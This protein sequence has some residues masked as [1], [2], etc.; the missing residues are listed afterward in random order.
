M[1]PKLLVEGNACGFHERASCSPDPSSPAWKRASIPYDSSLLRQQFMADVDSNNRRSSHD[2]YSPTGTS[3]KGIDTPDSGS[4]NL[5]HSATQST[6]GLPLNMANNAFPDVSAMMFP[7]ADPFAY[8][9]QPLSI[10]ENNQFTKQENPFNPDMCSPVANSSPGHASKNLDAQIF[11][12]LPPYL[13]QGLQPGMGIQNMNMP[14]DMGGLGSGMAMNSDEDQ[15]AQQQARTGGMSGMNL[16]QI[17][18]ED[19][20]VGWMD[21]FK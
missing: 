14:V 20:N 12:P 8:P 15:W 13:M 5:P 3:S 10:L 4:S 9:N 19:W 1:T 21:G 17:F 11:G 6:F 18:G 7:S 16:D 2:M